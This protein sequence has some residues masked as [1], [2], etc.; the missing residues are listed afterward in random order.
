MRHRDEGFTLVEL[1][2]AIVL[3][4]LVSGV[5]VAAMVTSMNIAD[6]TNDQLKDS[7]DASLISAFLYRDAQSAGGTD[8]A[9][10]GPDPSVGVSTSDWGECEQEESSLVV[11]FSW[12]DRE[13]VAIKSKVVATYALDSDE[14][15]VRRLCQ[16]GTTTDAVLARAVETVT[17]S[18]SPT[19]DQPSRVELAISGS[20][21]RSPFSFTLTASLRRDVQAQPDT[22][23]SS[24]VALVAFGGDSSP[25]PNLSMDE[26][27]KAMGDVAVGPVCVP[28]VAPLRKAVSS[29]WRWNHHDAVG[30]D[31]PAGRSRR[32]GLHLR[33]HR[34]Q[35]G[36]WN[37]GDVS[38]ARC[39]H[40][41]CHLPSWHLCVLRRP[42]DWSR[43][44]R[45]GRGRLLLRRR[46]NLHRWCRCD[47]RRPHSAV[48]GRI[49]ERSR[50]GGRGRHLKP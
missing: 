15:L 5:V 21:D 43:C 17:A 14:Q 30:N 46:W 33:R 4:G 36:R 6:S 10:A 23:N 19:C 20:G 27:V 26:T 49:Q 18:C 3:G 24:S 9:L 32:P 22:T 7:T 48:V 13:A 37:A 41:Q 45:H 16:D 35:P 29:T 8:P 44:L 12:Y 47:P 50:V 11:R 2:V 25:C 31:E 28:R 42:L 1:L 40:H 38:P 39:P 34:L